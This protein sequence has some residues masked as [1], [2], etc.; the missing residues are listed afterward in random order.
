MT[1]VNEVA[2]NLS[3]HEKACLE[4]YGHFSE[5][6]GKL[7]GTLGILTKLIWLVF[8]SV[9]AFELNALFKIIGH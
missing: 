7:E 2:K 4:R 9:A 1:D 3:D 8:A 5:R 6:F